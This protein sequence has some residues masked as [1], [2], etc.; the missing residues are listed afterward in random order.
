MDNALKSQCFSAKGVCA[1]NFIL[2]SYSESHKYLTNDLVGCS[3]DRRH[4]VI[5]RENR[6]TNEYERYLCKRLEKNA[7]ICTIT[8]SDYDSSGNISYL[9]VARAEDGYYTN[10]I[11]FHYKDENHRMD[12]KMSRESV[13]D[14]GETT[15]VPLLFA[16]R[17]LESVL[18]MQ[19]NSKT[20]VYK[21][22]GS[23]SRC[24]RTQI[25]NHQ[26]GRLHRLHTSGFVCVAG[27]SWPNLVLEFE[28][29]NARHL[30]IF[31]LDA[32]NNLK[33][34][35]IL[36]LPSQIGPIALADFNKSCCVDIAYVSKEGSRFYLNV[37][38]NLRAKADS[39]R[40]YDNSQESEGSFVKQ[41]IAESEEDYEPVL[42]DDKMGMPSGIFVVDLFCDSVQHIVLTTKHKKCSEFLIVL[43]KNNGKG[44]FSPIQGVFGEVPKHR[45]LSISFSDMLFAGRENLLVNF[46]ASTP[47][48]ECVLCLY[49]NN[50]SE[51]NYYFS[52]LTC[53]GSTRSRKAESFGPPL[54]GVSYRYKILENDTVFV[55]H[56]L[57]QSTFPHLQHQYAFFGLGPSSFY[58]IE[59]EGHSPPSFG[60]NV[61]KTGQKVIPNSKIV[62]Y[63][64]HNGRACMALNLS[65]GIQ[66]RNILTTIL[67]VSSLLLLILLGFFIRRRKLERRRKK[68]EGMA[69]DF[70]AL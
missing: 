8:P 35:E 9:I 14:I 58:L 33:C 16:L 50:L 3:D 37:V 2:L 29:D 61:K 27:S 48:K 25:H 46:Q 63:N 15:S 67:L 52:S 5:Y 60:Y 7:D 59:L 26:M 11:Y 45:I 28:E 62:L 38:F 31:G 13:E 47:E 55:G 6:R 43:M 70:G 36:Q 53:G 23:N 68:A 69:F 39:K 57:C 41:L 30:K 32:N 42:V 44:Q 65:P 18:L 56:Q 1:R 51:N 34:I 17:D 20:F 24:A 22:V 12:A 19:K 66:I 54:P 64:D 21:Y 49:K 10:T 4:M 40:I